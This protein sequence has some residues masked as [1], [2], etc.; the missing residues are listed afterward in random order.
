MCMLVDL[1]Q[2]LSTVCEGVYNLLFNIIKLSPDL[3]NTV[4]TWLGKCLHANAG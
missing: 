4:L 2:P 3:R 1:F